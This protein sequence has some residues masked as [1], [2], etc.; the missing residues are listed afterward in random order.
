MEFTIITFWFINKY[1]KCKM[2]QNWQIFQSAQK[3]YQKIEI[4]TK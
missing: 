2:A 3:W 1:R 4:Y